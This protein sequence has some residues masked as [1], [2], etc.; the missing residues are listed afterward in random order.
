MIHYQE[1]E[2]WDPIDWFIP[3]I[4]YMSVITSVMISNAISRGL[5]SVF[6]SLR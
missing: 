2:S 1:R 5:I 3:A 4:I 6:F